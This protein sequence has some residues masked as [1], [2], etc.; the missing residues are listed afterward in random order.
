MIQLPF[1][2]LPAFAG[3]HLDNLVTTDTAIVIT[4]NAAAAQAV[5]PTCG[6]SS[7]RIHSTYLRQPRDLPWAVAQSNCSCACGVSFVT[8]SPAPA[9]L[10][11]NK[12]VASL[13]PTPSAPLA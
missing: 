11:P 2:A 1:P 5:C 4:A 12:S 3:L 6:Q 8:R 9:P 7:T 13:G 10:S